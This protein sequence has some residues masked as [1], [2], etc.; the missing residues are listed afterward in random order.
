M[1][2][3]HRLVSAEFIDNRSSEMHVDHVDHSKANKCVYDLR[4]VTP[5][6]HHMITTS[7]LS[8]LYPFLVADD[9][10]H[11]DDDN[12][13]LIRWMIMMRIWMMSCRCSHKLVVRAKVC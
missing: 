5:S 10:S 1:L 6:Q 4:W 11:D 9:S 12:I 3:F 2:F 7:F 8:K 13:R